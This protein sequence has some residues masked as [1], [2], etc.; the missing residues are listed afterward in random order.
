[1]YSRGYPCDGNKTASSVIE[2]TCTKTVGR[3]AFKRSGDWGLS[4]GLC[5]EHTGGIPPWGFHGQVLAEC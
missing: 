3:P 1:M 2:L 4:A 5:S